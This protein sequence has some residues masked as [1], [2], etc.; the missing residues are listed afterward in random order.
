MPKPVKVGDF[1]PNEAC[2]EYGK[3]QSESGQRNILYVLQ[4]RRQQGQRYR[5]DNKQAAWQA[6]T[7]GIVSN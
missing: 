4:R 1:C 3:L 2:V 6:I 7:D 5:P